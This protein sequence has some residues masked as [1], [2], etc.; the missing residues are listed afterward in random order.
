MPKLR[1]TV[2]LA[3]LVAA[4]AILAAGVGGA[5]A[6]SKGKAPCWKAV[7]QDEYVPPIT[8]NYQLHCYREA[9]RHL[10]EDSLIYGAARQDIINAMNSAVRALQK[11]GVKVGPH[12]ILPGQ[13]GRGGDRSLQS[14]KR[15]KGFLAAIADKIGPGNASSIPLPLLI[16]AGLGLLLVAAAGASFTARWIASRRNGQPQPATSPP[17]PRRK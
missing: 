13:K 14:H 6:A 17:T 15:K 16:L 9:I 11:K 3:A 12:T 8:G 10:P 1:I 2:P 5:S 4:S 7:L